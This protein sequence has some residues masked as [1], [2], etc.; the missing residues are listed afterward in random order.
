MYFFSVKGLNLTLVPFGISLDFCFLKKKTKNNEKLVRWTSK[1]KV[2]KKNNE[3][4]L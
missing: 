3:N 2:H 4:K 1:R